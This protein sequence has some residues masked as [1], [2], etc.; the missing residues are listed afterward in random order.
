MMDDMHCEFCCV[1]DNED[2]MFVSGWVVEGV[3]NT[4]A[5]DRWYLACGDCG[6]MLCQR[7]EDIENDT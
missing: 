5:D 1:I 6:D 2:F 7:A 3:T 4:T